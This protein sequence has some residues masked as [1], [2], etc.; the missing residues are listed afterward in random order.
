MV[1][2]CLIPKEELL[3]CEHASLCPLKSKQSSLPELQLKKQTWFFLLGSSLISSGMSASRM[4]AKAS[5]FANNLENAFCGRDKET[6]SS[7][8]LSLENSE[9]LSEVTIPI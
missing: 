3:T 4:S 1:S 9:D 2:Q 8:D 7:M 6:V 5:V